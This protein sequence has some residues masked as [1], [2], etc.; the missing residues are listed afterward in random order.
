MK[1]GFFGTGNMGSAIA[2]GI[3]Q[4]SVDHEVYLYNPTI[5]KAKVL[6]QNIKGHVVDELDQMP[7]NLDWYFLA[8]KPQSLNQ[9]HFDFANDSKVISVLAGTSIY[10]L[11]QKFQT[12]KIVRLMPNTPSSIGKGVNLLFAK[13]SIDDLLPL[14]TATGKS[15]VLSDESLIDQLTPYSGSGPALIFEFASQ[16]E[17]NIFNITHDEELS[18]EIVAQL[19]IGSSALIK[20]G[21]ERQKSLVQLKDEVTSKKGVTFEALKVLDDHQFSSM[22][23]K[24]FDQAYQR[25]LELKQGL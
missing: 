18:R 24:A 16:F 19:F 1:I 23:K 14:I 15:F 4:H 10:T 22:M 17:K 5:E 8:F 25:A 6:S 20:N 7:R 9:F 2:Q 12:N 21:F 3:R 13:F 11:E